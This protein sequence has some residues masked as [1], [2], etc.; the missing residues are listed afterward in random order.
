MLA[1]N[2]LTT[3]ERMAL[4]LDIPTDGKKK[5]ERTTQIIELLINRASALIETQLG[6]HLGKDSYHQWYEAD[7]QQELITLEYPI[8]SVECIK[9]GGRL[10]DPRCYDFGQT[11]HIGV[12][13][14]DDGWLK[15]GYRR[16]LAFDIVELKRNIE[17]WYTAGYVL[18]K[19]ANKRN[20][21][22][23]PADLEGLVW[24]M[25]AQM[26]A[27]LSNGSHGLTA[28]SISDVSWHFDKQSNPEWQKIINLYRRY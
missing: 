14:R 4:M 11:G 12:I 18:P 25:V 20:P 21:Q 24:D 3:V 1:S 26:Y 7:G 22:T 10:V 9:E 13:Y 2:A 5:D 19:D 8:I 27:T 16:G 6:R 28:F 17:V 15:D 23:L